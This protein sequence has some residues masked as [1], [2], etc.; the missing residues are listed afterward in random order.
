MQNHCNEMWMRI[1][2]HHDTVRRYNS[3]H[4]PEPKHILNKIWTTI[5]GPLY[6][7][8]PTT[9]FSFN[10][11][12]ICFAFKK[13][14]GQCMLQIM[15]RRWPIVEFP[16]PCSRTWA[17]T[18][19]HF[20]YTTKKKTEICWACQVLCCRIVC[21][22]QDYVRSGPAWMDVEHIHMQSPIQLFYIQQ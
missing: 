20:F 11:K 8:L 13:V 2:V 14:W 3:E 19:I 21:W 5:K 12:Q 22:E 9:A 15:L 1:L 16:T 6:S 10:K 4:T 7:P 18:H 17:Q